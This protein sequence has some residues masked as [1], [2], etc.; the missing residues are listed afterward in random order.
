[1]I[2]KSDFLQYLEAPIHLWAQKHDKLTKTTPSAYDLHLMKQGYEVEG[3]AKKYLEQ[4]VLPK[5]KNA[6]MLWQPTYV[7]DDFHFRADA[8]IHDIDNDTYDIYEIKSSTS[9][10][11]EHIYDVTFQ[12]IV[13]GDLVEVGEVNLVLL[14]SKY[15]RGDELNLE[16]LF[17]VMKLSDDVAEIRQ[18]IQVKMD[19]A[20][21]VSSQINH[22]GLLNC[23]KP[24][25]CPCPELCHPDLP[26]LHIYNIPKLGKK[27]AR[28]L[29]ELGI[30]SIRDIPEDFKLSDRQQKIVDVIQSNMPYVSEWSISSFL[31]SITEP[32]YFLDYETYASAI[33]QY[34]GFHPYQQ[35]VFQFSL[36]VVRTGEKIP[37]HE[38]YLATEPEDPTL[39]LL[40]HLRDCVGDVGSVIVWN[41][42]FERDRNKEMAELH[43]E[44]SKFLLDMNKRMVDLA[45]LVKNG[46]YIHP[47]FLGS[48]SIK[49]VLPVMVPKLSY[50][51]LEIHQGDQAMSVW[52]EMVSGSKPKS[53][54]TIDALLKYCELDT[55]AMVKIWEKFKK[56]VD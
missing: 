14:N 34:P 51:S 8:L 55:L 33:P 22:T 1:M 2:T 53:K 54:A 49:S 19:Q 41:K 24:A 36:H 7:S 39:S 16:E 50:K 48:W 31:Q 28:A 44:Y 47:D 56:I 4:V 30:T 20:V 23:L 38:E 27:K 10:D 12:A 9:T 11:K 52:N 43:P 13:L 46:D 6:E 21:K 18:D 25:S 37:K 5:Y 29:Q 42:T 3:V 17:K 15:V 40:R 26:R 45:D 35:M 32:I